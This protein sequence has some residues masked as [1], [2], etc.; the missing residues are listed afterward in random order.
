MD[1]VFCIRE[2][3]CKQIAWEDWVFLSL[4][5]SSLL[6][7]RIAIR[8]SEVGY[9]KGKKGFY[10]FLA[11]PWDE[12]HSSICQALWST[13]TW[14]ALFWVLKIEDEQGPFNVPFK[15]LT[16][17]SNYYPLYHCI[18]WANSLSLNLTTSILC[19][20]A[21]HRKCTLFLLLQMEGFWQCCIDQI[22]QRHFPIVFSHFMSM[23]HFGNSYSI[24]NFFIIIMFVVVILDV[25][26][27]TCSSLS[28]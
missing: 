19:F 9:Y 17:S 8:V 24:S 1:R 23:S 26:T 13:S 5:K 20:I 12:F 27:T 25:T 28:A 3:W 16:M 15:E 7:R 14:D 21:H 4:L 11:S 2:A 18:P 10:S 6:S 22:Y